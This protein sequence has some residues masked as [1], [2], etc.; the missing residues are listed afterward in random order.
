MVSDYVNNA[1]KSNFV[2]DE[3]CNE[4]EASPS[5][6]MKG[7]GCPN[8]WRMAAKLPKEIVNERLNG[9]PIRLIG[10]YEYALTKTDFACDECGGEWLAS[11]SNVMQGTGCPHCAKHGFDPIKP[12]VLYYL[13][14]EDNGEVYYKI[15]ITNRSAAERFESQDMEKIT[16]L[17]EKRF[18][19]GADAKK[20][21]KE[22]L[23]KFKDALAGVDG[24]LRCGNTELFAYDIMGLAS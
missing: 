15:G 17:F 22:I 10:N 14:V 1:T 8:C 5:N 3:C 21:E 9:R 13:R 4:W 18:E 6:V 23:R 7:G 19:I 12:A 24:V 16:V 20:A 11:P 2:C